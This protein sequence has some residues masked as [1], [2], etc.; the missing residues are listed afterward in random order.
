MIWFGIALWVIASM[1]DAH[2]RKDKYF[3]LDYR[4]NKT[5]FWYYVAHLIWSP[6]RGLEYLVVSLKKLGS[7][8]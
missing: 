8:N 4:D 1:I 7:R 3:G 2:R 6:A 5:M